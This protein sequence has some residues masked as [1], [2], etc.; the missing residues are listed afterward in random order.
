MRWWSAGLLG[1]ATVGTAVCLAAGVDVDPLSGS[2]L[3]VCLAV[4]SATVGAAEL[5]A[6]FLARAPLPARSPAAL[7]VCDE[8][9]SDLATVVLA[10]M[11][12]PMLLSLFVASRILPEA[13]IVTVVLLVLPV[14]VME[15]RRRRRVRERLWP[16]APF[17][18]GA[19]PAAEA[20]S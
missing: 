13:G 3:A 17:G 6:R 7:A 15:Q 16:T 1:L 10:G 19:G 9:R 18:A 8:V 11:L 14:A 4:S 2:E 20:P 5:A 12:G